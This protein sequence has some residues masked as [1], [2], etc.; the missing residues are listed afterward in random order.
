MGLV[1]YKSGLKESVGQESFIDILKHNY[2]EK[3]IFDFVSE[4]NLINIQTEIK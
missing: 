2:H 3:A 4:E 1:G